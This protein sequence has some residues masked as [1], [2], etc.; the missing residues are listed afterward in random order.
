MITQERLKDLLRYNSETGVF[1]WCKK[2]GNVK[3]GSVAGCVNGHG[4][5]LI[6]LDKTLYKAHRLAWLYVY[7]EWPKADIDHINSMKSD[8]RIVNLRD[9]TRAENK[10]NLIVPYAGS[11]SGFLGVT[12]HKDGF[13]AQI[14]VDGERIYLG[15]YD[16]AKSAQ[17]AYI[18]AKRAMYPMGML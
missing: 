3:A 9:V 5:Q 4:Y 12:P 17:C 11:S 16:T 10:Q 13:V 1:T 6:R 15:K 2:R 14:T 7:G 8:N 18:A